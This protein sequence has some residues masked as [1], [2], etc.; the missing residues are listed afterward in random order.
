MP[1]PK[2][3]IS[4]PLE[5]ELK[6]EPDVR[7]GFLL[8]TAAEVFVAEGY[9]A[10]SVGEIAR[11]AKASK[12]T[13]YLH[14][15]SKAELFQAVI[16]WRADVN[17]RR[18][19]SLLV[20]GDPP[21][22]ALTAFGTGLLEMV[23]DAS[24]V[25]V[26]RLVYMESG[27]FPQLGKLLYDQGA[28]RGLV[29]MEQYIRQQRGMGRLRVADTA[30]A[31]EQF[32]DMISGRLLMRAALGLAPKPPAKDKRSRVKAAVDVFLAAYGCENE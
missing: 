29:L 5:S 9:E 30:I 4:S 7:L 13:I 2:S 25:G 14:Y 17:Y 12:Q 11:R 6:D 19:S 24:A 23:L 20:S 18:L 10:A 26:L 31:A 21:R 3:L 15:P 22:K 1:K 32:L 16:A 28:G 8:D 27:R